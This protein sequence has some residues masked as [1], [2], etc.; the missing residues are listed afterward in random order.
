MAWE[1]HVSPQ[2]TTTGQVGERICAGAHVDIILKSSNNLYF[3]LRYLIGRPDHFTTT[4]LE[5]L[6]CGVKAKFTLAYTT[7]TLKDTSCLINIIW[8]I[9]RHPFSLFDEPKVAVLGAHHSPADR[10]RWVKNRVVFNDIFT[11]KKRGVATDANIQLLLGQIIIL[12]CVV[13][14]AIKC[15]GYILEHI[16]T[17][18]V[19][20]EASAFVALYFR[21][22]GDARLWID[23]L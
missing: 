17:D 19:I 5:S 6:L 8:S 18:Y 3:V 11:G 21:R 15:C 20:K 10:T 16:V 4:T 13:S 1:R 7:I 12:L 2:V 14:S 23:K 9:R 22:F